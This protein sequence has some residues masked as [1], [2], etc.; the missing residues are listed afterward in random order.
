MSILAAAA[1]DS[2]GVY[3]AI[4]L[5]ALTCAALIGATCVGAFRADS[6]S[7]PLRA[8]PGRSAQAVVV[9]LF[10]G[11]SAWLLT[12][13]AFATI[14]QVML[15]RTLGPNARFDQDHF[16][17]ADWAYMATVPQVVGFIALFA[18]DLAAGGRE[19]LARLGLTR[20]MLHGVLTGV[21]GIVI[22]LPLVIAVSVATDWVYRRLRFQHPAE[23]DLLR[24]MGSAPSRA[25]RMALIGGAVLVAPLFEEYLFRGHVQTFLRTLLLLG[26]APRIARGF[27]VAPPD[28]LEGS[29]VPLIQPTLSLSWPSPAPRRIASKTWLAIFLTS[30]LFAV[31]HPRWTWPP[32]AFLAICLGFAYERTGNLWTCITMH[33]LFNSFETIAYLSRPTG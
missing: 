8:T 6:V 1:A 32:I 27:P 21:V 30:I 2:G 3:S 16:T 7:G 5:L 22:A 14:R 23:H 20:R 18:A 33:A 4:A 17:P 24:E 19:L 31:I 10:M 28:G 11:V 26:R 15:A 25:L 12:P 13:V 9:A 29:P